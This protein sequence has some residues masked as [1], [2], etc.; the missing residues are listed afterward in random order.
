MTDHGSFLIGGLLY[1]GLCG[2]VLED[3]PSLATAMFVVA[4]MYLLT[5]RVLYDGGR[6]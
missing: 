6:P 1:L 3:D 4:V 2:L 5:S